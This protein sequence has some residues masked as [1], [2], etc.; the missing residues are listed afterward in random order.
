[1]IPKAYYF[2]A[3]AVLEF[4]EATNSEE[5]FDEE[6]Y[7][8]WMLD[9]LSQTM[10][11]TNLLFRVNPKEHAKDTLSLNIKSASHRYLF[12]KNR[13][14]IHTQAMVYLR[15]GFEPYLSITK[16]TNSGLSKAHLLYAEY[17]KHSDKE[18]W[19]KSNILRKKGNLI[20]PEEFPEEKIQLNLRSRLTDNYSKGSASPRAIEEIGRVVVD[21]KSSDLVLPEEMG[22][23]DILSNAPK[24]QSFEKRGVRDLKNYIVSTLDSAGKR[25]SA[26]RRCGLDPC[27]WYSA[28]EP[29]ITQLRQMAKFINEL[30]LVRKKHPDRCMEDNLAD[31]W[32]DHPIPDMASLKDL[33]Q[34]DWGRL[35][36]KK[37]FD[38][39]PKYT[40]S[41]GVGKDAADFIRK[42]QFVENM[43]GEL[44]ILN[45]SDKVIRRIIKDLES[46]E[47]I[48]KAEA[49]YL[50]LC[51][52]EIKSS[53]DC[54]NNKS[55]R[56]MFL[57]QMGKPTGE[58]SME[59]SLDIRN[60][61]DSFESSLT[62]KISDFIKSQDTQENEG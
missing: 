48:T 23:K 45:R 35:V 36:I 30:R 26:L 2:L 62:M 3:N 7:T 50:I 34:S 42:A 51:S 1:M 9:V 8:L 31:V 55:F 33:L 12:K 46:N 53:S 39:R 4:I 21:L 15:C 27:D 37:L 6:L 38:Y 41:E 58:T 24:V 17:A 19:S 56:E 5:V 13:I 10:C 18:N 40:A 22:V 47:W 28:D 49:K 25:Y 60:K 16:L 29:S 54:L 57:K 11:V 44:D 52:I 32:L 61:L 20:P 59:R 43:L 14:F